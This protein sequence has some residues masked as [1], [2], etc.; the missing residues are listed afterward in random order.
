M[1]PDACVFKSQ[2]LNAHSARFDISTL[3]APLRLSSLKK[4]QVGGQTL[5]LADRLSHRY[6]Q[7]GISAQDLITDNIIQL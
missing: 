5:G 3:V 6:F 7:I 1:A 2:R 4:S